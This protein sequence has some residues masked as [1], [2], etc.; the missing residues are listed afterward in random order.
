MTDEEW[1]PE[2]LPLLDQL[3]SFHGLDCATKDE[4]WAHVFLAGYLDRPPTGWFVLD[5]M[6]SRGGDWVA[7]MV[8]V[9][10]D[11]LKHCLC[12]IAFLYVHPN[13][14]RPDESRTARETWV[15]VPGN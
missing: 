8:E 7:L 2:D 11:E 9:H 4:W 3:K 1:K 12:K 10:P 13:E 6:R 5:V 14:Y 15:R